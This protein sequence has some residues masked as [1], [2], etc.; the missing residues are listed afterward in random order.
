MNKHDELSPV[1]EIVNFHLKRIAYENISTPS[2]LAALTIRIPME[3]RIQL[4]I[5]ST[6][7]G[8]S[9]NALLNDLLEPV[10]EEAFTQLCSKDAPVRDLKINGMT[11]QQMLLQALHDYT[12][13]DGESLTQTGQLEQLAKRYG[14]RVEGDRVYF[15]KPLEELIK[16]EVQG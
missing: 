5:L 15:D 1:R 9:R 8:I 4:D 11:P 3:I 13:N 14:G 12:R 10:V 7:L 6:F 2:D 16:E